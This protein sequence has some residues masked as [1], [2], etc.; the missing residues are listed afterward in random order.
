MGRTK[1]DIEQNNKYNIFIE[2]IKE[3]YRTPAFD[4]PH[5]LY[6]YSVQYPENRT[7]NKKPWNSD[8]I[9]NKKYNHETPKNCNNRSIY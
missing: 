3:G 6:S 2:P 1:Y 8:S 4:D 7:Y 5:N 9:W